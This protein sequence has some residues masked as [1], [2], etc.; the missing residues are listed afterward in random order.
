MAMRSGKNMFKIIEEY[1]SFARFKRHGENN[2]RRPFHRFASKTMENDCSIDLEVGKLWLSTQL[3]VYSRQ[4]F[5]LYLFPDKNER[6]LCRN[7]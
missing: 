3:P 7:V 4:I 1:V 2:K 6:S 5:A